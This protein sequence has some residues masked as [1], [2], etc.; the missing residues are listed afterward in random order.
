MVSSSNQN[1]ELYSH[2]K[3]HNLVANLHVK[4]K[5]VL[6]IWRDNILNVIILIL[7]LLF[8]R[9]TPFLLSYRKDTI[10]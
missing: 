9:Q 4:F 6:R 1:F 8:F 2:V 5:T 7:F 10:R 3:Q